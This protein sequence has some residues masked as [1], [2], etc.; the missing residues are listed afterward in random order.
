METLLSTDKICTKPE[1]TAGRRHHKKRQTS[2]SAGCN[3]GRG[4]LNHR[5]QPLIDR[6]WPFTKEQLKVERHFFQSLHNFCN[7]YKI[8]APDYLY[9]VYPYN[10]N[11]YYKWAKQILAILNPAL[12]LLIVQSE[13]KICLA[14][15]GICDTRMTLFYIP[16]KPV[17][18]LLRTKKTKALGLLVL[19]TCSWLHQVVRVDYYTEQHSYL[20]G[21]YESIG[22]WLADAREDYEK[23]DYEQQVAELG[24]AESEGKW[25]FKKLTRKHHLSSWGSR[26][27]HFVPL[28]QGEKL[29][30]EACKKG[31]ELYTTYPSRNAFQNIS[32]EEEEDR[33]DCT[34]TLDQYLSFCWDVGGWVSDQ[35]DEWV[36]SSFQEGVKDEPMS[37]QFF[38]YPQEKEHHDLKFEERLFEFI[39]DFVYA[40]IQLS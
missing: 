33:D 11:L 9:A 4:F 5:F 34:L 12:D 23:E 22:N 18:Q 26:M 32:Y 2:T 36:N 38:D 1:R 19:S 39:D 24:V 8:E 7:C 40:L 30:Y 3:A 14:T 15:R 6:N 10:I 16:I 20:S 37:M 17:V 27:M 35:V 29:L 28:H 25:L 13:S 21:V 31:W